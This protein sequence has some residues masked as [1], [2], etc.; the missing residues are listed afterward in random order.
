MEIGAGVGKIWKTRVG[1]GVGVAV[2]VRTDDFKVMKP[3]VD[4]QLYFI[5]VLAVLKK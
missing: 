1:V 4:Q 3:T 2:T 5:T